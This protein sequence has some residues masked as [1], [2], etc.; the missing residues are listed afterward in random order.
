MRVRNTNTSKHRY[1]FG[2]ATVFVSSP[3]TMVLDG[4]VP[5]KFHCE[6]HPAGGG[7]VVKLDVSD[8]YPWRAAN[9]ALETYKKMRYEN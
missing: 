2:T 7:P 5:G 3:T 8:F 4:L 9:T 6:I 1:E